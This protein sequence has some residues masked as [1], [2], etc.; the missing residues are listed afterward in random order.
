MKRDHVY[1]K[2]VWCG[3]RQKTITTSGPVSFAEYYCQ[4]CGD[5]LVICSDVRKAKDE[6]KKV[7]KTKNKKKQKQKK[8]GGKRHQIGCSRLSEP[9]NAIGRG[10]YTVD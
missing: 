4:K 3:W 9:V 5:Q 6:K 1:S 10:V 2:C 8:K 7:K